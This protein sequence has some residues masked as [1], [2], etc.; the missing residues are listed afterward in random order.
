MFVIKKFVNNNINR[1]I[2]FNIVKNNE[3][4]KYLFF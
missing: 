4:W 1:N 3:L 2:I